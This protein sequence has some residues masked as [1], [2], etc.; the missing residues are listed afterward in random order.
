MCLQCTSAHHV[1]ARTPHFASGGDEY[2]L[3]ILIK[4]CKVRA[5]ASPTAALA[6][7]QLSIW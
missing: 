7:C 1:R 3:I 4:S 6:A 5:I 2:L